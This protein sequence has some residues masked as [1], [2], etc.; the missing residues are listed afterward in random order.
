MRPIVVAA[1][2][3]ERG[4]VAE[5][6]GVAVFFNDIAATGCVLL[7]SSLFSSFTTGD[8]FPSSS[9][10]L[11]VTAAAPGT[12]AISVSVVLPLG[13]SPLWVV[14]AVRKEKFPGKINKNFPFSLAKLGTAQAD[15]AI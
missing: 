10:S 9:P 1:A 3:E 5:G 15:R 2:L 6:T 12:V 14:V 8:G 13:S 11:C 7:W 4:G